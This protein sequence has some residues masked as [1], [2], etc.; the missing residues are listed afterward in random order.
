MRGKVKWFNA[1]K[2]YG[3]VR[4][5]DGKEYFSHIRD[6]ADGTDDLADGQT[7]EFQPSSGP[8]G[9]KAASLRL[10]T[11]LLMVLSLTAVAAI[12]GCTKPPKS[13]I[14]Q[15]YRV[16]AT[17]QQ[18]T[19][20]ADA[21]RGVLWAKTTATQ[22]TTQVSLAEYEQLR[23][24]VSYLRLLV[25]TAAG[26]MKRIGDYFESGKDTPLPEGGQ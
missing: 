15:V 11:V 1:E 17:L 10:V 21:G 19:D 9:L 24:Q 12:G 3:F 4:G 20:E 2:G 26:E 13:V 8:K 5:E 25:S 18:T 22:P 6:F 14:N 23:E 7:V 16:E